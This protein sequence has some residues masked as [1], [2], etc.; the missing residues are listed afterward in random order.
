MDTSHAAH[1]A[2]RKRQI[3]SQPPMLRRHS[4]TNCTGV[5]LYASG[6]RNHLQRPHEHLLTQPPQANCW[7]MLALALP[8]SCVAVSQCDHAS[9][10]ITSLGLMVTYCLDLLGH[11]Y[12]TLTAWTLSMVV[13]GVTAALERAGEGGGVLVRVLVLIFV[14]Q[15][16]GWG[17]LQFRWLA[18]DE[19]PLYRSLNSHV[20]A[21][22]PVTCC[23]LIAWG[24]TDL[25][26]G[27]YAA[28]A[29][30]MA[31]LCGA[32]W[33]MSMVKGPETGSPSTL[34]LVICLLV[35]PIAT[36]MGSQLS[37]S[38][39]AG[40]GNLWGGTV[41]QIAEGSRWAHAVLWLTLPWIALW[42]QS[43]AAVLVLRAVLEPGERFPLPRT[44]PLQQRSTAGGLYDSA[45]ARIARAYA[46]LA[47]AWLLSRP[48]RRPHGGGRRRAARASSTAALYEGG[49]ASPSGGGAGRGRGGGGGG[50]L[51]AAAVG[52]CGRT[53]G[54]LGAGA[55]A[56]CG[57]ATVLRR[58][59]GAVVLRR[60]CWRCAGW[61]GGAAAAAVA[62]VAAAAAAACSALP[63]G[64]DVSLAAAVRLPLGLK[65]GGDVPLRGLSLMAI[66]L[67]AG[68]ALCSN[69]RSVVGPSEGYLAGERDSLGLSA[70]S[71][72]ARSGAP[73][74]ACGSAPRRR[75]RLPRVH[76]PL[77]PVQSTAVQRST[78]RGSSAGGRRFRRPGS[79]AAAQRSSDLLRNG[80]GGGSGAAFDLNLS[81]GAQLSLRRAYA[82]FAAVAA[83]TAAAAPA[84]LA[85]AAAALGGGGLGLQPMLVAAAAGRLW[86]CGGWRC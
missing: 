58:W 2:F 72:G 60:R 85:P 9:T 7:Q 37:L 23:A 42:T 18:V 10:L 11:R 53:V 71:G 5:P 80:G 76:R 17:V 30:T 12:G 66:A 45:A 46:A 3:D 24:A 31:V 19:L 20:A 65:F 61:R 84:I 78:R 79:S 52:G 54:G 44:Q 73:V 8:A 83:A 16:T 43:A 75:V 39:D 14:L 22:L 15:V 51:A 67:G 47:A 64:L 55:A 13:G 36:F 1:T 26:D 27:S 25:F 62:A 32:L 70:G 34:P 6:G 81:T 38:A 74:D 28:P 86:R 49:V 57:A 56:A 4:T 68:F 41:P 48:F 21:Y 50:A 40:Y 63:V 33:L 29:C 59:P 69:G 77:P 82:H 35:A